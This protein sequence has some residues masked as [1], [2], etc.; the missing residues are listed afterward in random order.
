MIKFVKVLAEHISSLGDKYDM[1]TFSPTSRFICTKGFIKVGTSLVVLPYGY[2][3]GD[4]KFKKLLKG[5]FYQYV[6]KN[7]IVGLRRFSVSEGS[8]VVSNCIVVKWNDFKQFL[9][10]GSTAQTIG[11]DEISFKLYE[12]MDFSGVFSAKGLQELIEKGYSSG[13]ISNQFLKNVHTIGDYQNEKGIP[14]SFDVS[15]EN[16]K[17]YIGWRSFLPSRKEN[18]LSLYKKILNFLRGVKPLP[19][20]VLSIEADRTLAFIHAITG[21]LVDAKTGGYTLYVGQNISAYYIPTDQNTEDFI[22]DNSLMGFIEFLG[23]LNIMYNQFYI[24]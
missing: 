8:D 21:Y 2:K 5:P 14:L 4:N 3:V 20:P 22:A 9:K 10:R 1:V 16:V 18:K 11:Q 12:F 24:K 19:K 6:L 7:N 15:F 17:P 13:K 23:G